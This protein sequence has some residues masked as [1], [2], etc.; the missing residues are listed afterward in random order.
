M[1]TIIVKVSNQLFEIVA[2]RSNL[3]YAIGYV[4]REIGVRTDWHIEIIMYD[5]ES[6]SPFW[7]NCRRDSDNELLYQCRVLA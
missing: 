1:K 4:N 7:Y 3:H 5:S 2:S 6:D